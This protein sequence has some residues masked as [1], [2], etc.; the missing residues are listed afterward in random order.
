MAYS[1]GSKVVIGDETIV[2]LTQDTV[3]AGKMLAG[4]TAH[5]KAGNQVTGSI[6]ILAGQTITPTRNAQ[7]IATNGKYLSGDIV[8]SGIPAS[9][10][11]A[12]EALNLLFPV[13][14]IYMSTSSTAPTFGG[15]WEEILITD[16]WAEKEADSVSYAAGTGTG[17]VHYW[18]RTA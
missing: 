8:I 6:Q 7:T 16:T 3:T 4:F 15:T 11:T 12:E 9:Y 5:D 1:P 10:Y 17:T 13:G 14:S 2:D 18:R